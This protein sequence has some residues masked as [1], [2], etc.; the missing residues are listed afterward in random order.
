MDSCGCSCPS[1]LTEAKSSTITSGI[2]NVSSQALLITVQGGAVPVPV[3]VKQKETLLSLLQFSSKLYI[4]VG[5]QQTPLL[6]SSNLINLCKVDTSHSSV[7]SKC[8][9]SPELVDYLFTDTNYNQTSHTC[10][11]IPLMAIETI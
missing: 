5:V 8:A 11:N 2:I 6:I 4:P 10:G 1:C 9:A 3:C 7:F